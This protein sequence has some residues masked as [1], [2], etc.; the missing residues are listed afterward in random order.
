[1]VK[2]CSRGAN[3]TDPTLRSTPTDYAIDVPVLIHWGWETRGNYGGRRK[4]G[5]RNFSNNFA[6]LFLDYHYD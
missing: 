3:R 2:G 5:A 6:H 4:E 1:M